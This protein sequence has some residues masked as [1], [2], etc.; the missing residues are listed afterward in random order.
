[1]KEIM[2]ASLALCYVQVILYDTNC[3]S[4]QELRIRSEKKEIMA[5]LFVVTV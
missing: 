2:K 4:F 1:M 5:R 3:N